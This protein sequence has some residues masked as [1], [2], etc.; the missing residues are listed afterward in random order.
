MLFSASSTTFE[1]QSELSIDVAYDNAD[2]YYTI[3][4]ANPYNKGSISHL[5]Q[6]IDELPN[7]DRESF[8]NLM[9]E[10]RNYFSLKK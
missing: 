1:K 4:T 5:K 2:L 3:Q 8:L 10:S 7:L 6:S 9:S